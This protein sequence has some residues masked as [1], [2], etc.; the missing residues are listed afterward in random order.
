MKVGEENEEGR[1]LNVRGFMNTNLGKVMTE[2][3]V[4][5]VK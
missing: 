1:F 5:E 2:K 3:W 4:F